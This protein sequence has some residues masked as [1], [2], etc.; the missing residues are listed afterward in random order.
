MNTARDMKKKPTRRTY[1]RAQHLRIVPDL[2]I[3]QGICADAATNFT[4]RMDSER[5]D[6]QLAPIWAETLRHTYTKV[7]EEPYPELAA[8]NGSILPIDTSVDPES[9]N[10]EYFMIQEYGFA[11]WMDDDGQQ[12]PSSTVTAERFTGEHHEITHRWNVTVFDVARAA[13]SG[14]LSLLSIKNSAARKAHERTTNWVWLFGESGKNLPG[15]CNNPDIPMTLAPLNTGA[16][17]RLPANKTN[18]EIVAD[19]ALLINQ[20]PVRTRR[21]NFVAKVYVSL[22]LMQLCQDRK[23]SGLGDG[24][25]NMIVSLWD[26]IKKRWSGDDTGQGAVKFMV[27]NECAASERSDPRSP[28]GADTSGIDGDFMLA[29]P[30]DSDRNVFIRSRPFTQRP[31]EERDMIMHHN[32]HSKIGGAR[33]QEPMAFQVVRF[34]TT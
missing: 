33:I 16:S 1:D 19:F 21:Q 14:M 26:Y 2:G 24:S 8:A 32:T 20:V 15:L 25:D 5:G 18:A 6:D 23:L 34:G 10:W 28:S 9:L 31:P 3:L 7:L 4:G 11:D 29:C 22:E 12:A 30:A 13:K 17:S 27:L